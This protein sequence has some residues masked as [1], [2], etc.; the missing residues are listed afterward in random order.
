[1]IPRTVLI[2]ATPFPGRLSGT[3]VAA[4]L[5]L[6]LETAVHRWRVERWAFEAQATGLDPAR[7]DGAL[8]A[9]PFAPRLHAARALVLADPDL[10]G[11]AVPGNASFELA[12]AARQ[13]GV[14]AYAV[15]ATRT[16]NL[17]SARV[18]DLQAV[19]CARSESELEAAG[20]QLATLI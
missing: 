16:D 5:A 1:M 19:V 3:R 14:P 7:A 11:H 20:Q 13:R 8:G 10:Y 6:G 4:A 18:M 12:T 9:G 15:T 17:F 2:V